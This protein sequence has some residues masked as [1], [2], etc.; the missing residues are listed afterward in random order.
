MGGIPI[1][2]AELL[3][4]FLESFFFGLYTSSL[5]LC[6]AIHLYPFIILSRQADFLFFFGVVL[7]LFHQR[8]ATNQPQ[9][10]ALLSV[11]ILMLAMATLV[12][13]SDFRHSVRRF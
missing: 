4:L 9:W 6:A 3:A 1:D 8:V 11:S 5:S 10:R 2:K 12:N 13:S 7:V